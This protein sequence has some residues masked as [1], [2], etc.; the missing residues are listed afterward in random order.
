MHYLRLKNL[1]EQALASLPAPHTPEV[2]E[3]VFLAIEQNPIWRKSYDEVVY[4]LGKP[5]TI[6]WA[7][8]WIA[9]AEGR[10]GDQR[11]T[12]TR[13]ALI[14]SFARMAAPAAKRGKKVKEPD[15]VQ[16]MH[17][18][19]QAHRDELPATIREHRDVIVALIMEGIAADAAYATVM[20]KPAY[21]W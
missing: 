19:F 3:D 13:A 14:D 20:E 8:F 11:E 9:H 15:A 16:A 21:A 5:V 7:G 18:Y 6:A 1:V 2:V 12:A 17:D 10:V 4:K